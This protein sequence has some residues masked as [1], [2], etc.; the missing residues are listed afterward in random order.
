MSDI[1]R[2]GQGPYWVKDPRSRLP[3]QIDWTDWLTHEG[4]TIGASAWVADAGVTLDTPAATA[5]VATVWVSGGTAGQV[6]ALRN[7]IT[8]MNGAIDSRSLRVVI[9]DL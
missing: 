3:V 7:T 2:D 8:A 4:T 9:R 6:V 1:L 5:Q